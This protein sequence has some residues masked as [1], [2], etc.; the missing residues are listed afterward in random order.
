MIA[1]IGVAIGG[2]AGASLIMYAGV[3]A[4]GAPIIGYAIS[5]GKK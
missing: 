3:Y 2:V 1:Q 5:K 4:L